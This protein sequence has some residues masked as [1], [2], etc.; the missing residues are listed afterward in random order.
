MAKGHVYVNNRN[1]IITVR[2]D[3]AKLKGYSSCSILHLQSSQTPRKSKVP[4]LKSYQGGDDSLL[5]CLLHQLL[6]IVAEANE[7][8]Q[9]FW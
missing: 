2:Y 7:E 4:H 6:S 5:D 3:E 8:R 9:I 1:L